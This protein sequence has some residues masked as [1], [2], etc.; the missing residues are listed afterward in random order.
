M[1]SREILSREQWE[2]WHR[3]TETAAFLAFL[4]AQVEEAKS[5]WA[6]GEFSK[7]TMSVNEVAV[8]N[9]AAVENIQFAERIIDLDYDTYLNAL[10]D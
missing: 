4:R 9:L 5:A 10:K 8:A 6:N 3:Q 1:D 2:A 7:P